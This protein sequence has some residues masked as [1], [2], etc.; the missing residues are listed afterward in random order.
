M[1]PLE[2]FH[3]EL[4][5]QQLLPGEPRGTLFHLNLVASIK[6]SQKKYVQKVWFPYLP[7]EITVENKVHTRI[8][9]LGTLFITVISRGT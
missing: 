5:F 1:F 2:Y 8:F 9:S 4:H 6:G 7:L 3:W